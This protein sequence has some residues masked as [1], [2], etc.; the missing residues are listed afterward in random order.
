M[1][2]KVE[3]ARS[4]LKVEYLYNELT[5]E[6]ISRIFAKHG[7]LLFVTEVEKGVAYVRYLDE[8]SGQ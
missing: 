7:E 6:D 5:Q 8:D 4:F 1:E 3:C 2:Y